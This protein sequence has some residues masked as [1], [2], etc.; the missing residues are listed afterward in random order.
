MEGAKV[1]K[2]PL[3]WERGRGVE[4]VEE[5]LLPKGAVDSTFSTNSTGALAL[6]ATVIPQTSLLED[7]RKYASL[8]LESADSYVVGA[9]LPVSPLAW[10]SRTIFSVGR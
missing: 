1:V 10:A 5:P 3:E 7:Y 8:E 4:F 2:P 9:F 6:E